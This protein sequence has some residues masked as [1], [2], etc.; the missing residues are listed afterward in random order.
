MLLIRTRIDRSPI[1]G[2]GLYAL[3]PIHK[4][5]RTWVFNGVLDSL[6]SDDEYRQLPVTTQAFIA[7]F[8]VYKGDRKSHL[9]CGDHARFLNHLATP[10]LVT[11][12]DYTVALGDIATGDEL[13]CN[14]FEFDDHAALKLALC[15]NGAF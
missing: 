6:V 15:D 8:A 13:T 10:N 12:G 7:T 1:H 4:G 14:Y 5:Q 11:V 9:L 2:I 3:E